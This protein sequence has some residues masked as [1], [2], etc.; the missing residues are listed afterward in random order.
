MKSSTKEDII[1]VPERLAKPDILI[2]KAMDDIKDP[3]KFYENDDLIILKEGIKIKVS[4][5]KN[6]ISLLQHSQSKSSEKKQH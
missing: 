6:I 2:K 3:N 1:Q 4:N 5:I